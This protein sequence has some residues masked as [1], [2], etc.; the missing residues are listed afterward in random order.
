MHWDKLLSDKILGKSK[1]ERESVR[2]SFE[3]D[4][5]RII[6]SYPF[7]RL[8]DKTQVFPMPVHDFV[9]SRL[10]HSL[11]VSSVGRSLGKIA[12]EAIISRYS[13][14]KNSNISPND[15]G[16]IVAAASLAH[17]IGN[18]PFG[19]AGEKAIS[20]FFISSSPGQSFKNQLTMQQWEDIINFEGNAQGFKLLNKKEYQGLKLTYST[21]LA[22]TKYPRES[23]VPGRNKERKSQKK[24][25]FFQSEK[26]IFKAL[27]EEMELIRLR[28]DAFVWC[29]HPLAFL[30]EAA[31]DICYNIIDLE[32]ACRLDLVS[33][34]DTQNL[35]AEVIGKQFQPEKLEKIRSRDEKLGILRAMAIGSL[36]KQSAEIFLEHENDIL[37]GNFDQALTDKI[38]SNGTMEE[39]SKL[40]ISKIYQSRP[41]L[42]REV[43]GFEVL[44]GLLE[45]FTMAA[46]NYFKDPNAC[47]ARDRNI[48]RLI[49]EEYQIFDQF[50]EGEEYDLLMNIIDFIAS[51]TDKYAITL[52]RNIKGIAFPA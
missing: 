14:L 16:A 4:F 34:H 26:E 35:L 17:D 43:T 37:S 42:E 2:S 12:G 19:H 9:H 33:Y 29:R 21:L 46:L 15:F 31:D 24:Y 50:T 40:S 52:Y 11:E 49:P 20:D 41:V 36:I 51:M 6:F 13:K 28:E 23:L 25:G 30:V 38:I 7:R 48:I 45:T 3:R 10:T 1:D 32:D 47:S 27:A 22:F 5:D 39:I 44:H 8:Q 18:P